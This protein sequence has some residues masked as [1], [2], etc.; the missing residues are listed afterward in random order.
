MA[1]LSPFRVDRPAWLGHELC[2]DFGE[3]AH[4]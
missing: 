2:F 4:K 1:E 3:V